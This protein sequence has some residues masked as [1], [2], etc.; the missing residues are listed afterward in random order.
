[1]DEDCTSEGA[2]DWNA[3]FVIKLA[4]SLETSRLPMA[5]IYTD[6]L[7]FCAVLLENIGNI[8][9]IFATAVCR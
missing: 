5:H 3:S 9:Y 8:I 7:E 2:Q 6:T 4:E 1:M